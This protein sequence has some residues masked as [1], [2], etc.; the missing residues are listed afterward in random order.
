MARGRKRN[1]GLSAGQGKSRD[2]RSC[3]RRGYIGGWIRA[4]EAM[5]EC[6]K[7]LPPLPVVDHKYHDCFDHTIA[8]EY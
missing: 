3:Y 8:L 2:E 5:D 6:L 7:A 4:L 1:G